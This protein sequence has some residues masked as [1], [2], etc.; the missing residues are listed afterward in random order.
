M[1]N[2]DSSSYGYSKNNYDNYE[3]NKYGNKYNQGQSSLSNKYTA[4]SLDR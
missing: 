4:D 1:N 2:G 3:N